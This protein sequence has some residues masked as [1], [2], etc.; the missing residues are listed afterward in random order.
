MAFTRDAAVM[1][2]AHAEGDRFVVD[3]IERLAP[4]PGQP[5]DA[6][7]TVA[8]FA[9]ILRAYDIR[10]IFTDQFAAVPL[11]AEFRRHGIT[12]TEETATSMSKVKHYGGLREAF[13][14]RRVSM[15]KHEIALRELTQLE[16]RITGSGNV[17]IGH[18]VGGHDDCASAIAWAFVA[19]QFAPVVGEPFSQKFYDDFRRELA[20][21][22]DRLR[23][24]GGISD[25]WRGGR[26]GRG[27]GL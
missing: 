23:D 6:P 5:L 8:R 11:A 7:A 9:E 18:P 24:N 1:A 19:L 16:E 20:A 22:R 12:L 25:A 2:I 27:G 3:L 13:Y 17:Q 21:D 10:Q 14:A 4:S 26:W 15:P